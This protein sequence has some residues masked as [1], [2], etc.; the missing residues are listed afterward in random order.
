M[1]HFIDWKTAGGINLGKS[2]SRIFI[3]Y[4]QI[5]STNSYCRVNETKMTGESF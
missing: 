5:H 4:V 1:R 2:Y 3:Q